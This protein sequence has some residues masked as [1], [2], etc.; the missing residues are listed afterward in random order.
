MDGESGVWH[1]SNA[2]AVSWA[3]LALRA[4]RVALTDTR[5]LQPCQ[6]AE[7][8][9][10]ARRPRYSALGT[11]RAFAMPALDDALARCLAHASHARRWRHHAEP[12][13][14]QSHTP[15]RASVIKTHD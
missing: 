1:L 2:G 12:Q 15:R 10:P 3:E 9:L 8:G 13:D 7:L 5:S 6:S 14:R 11:S 4:A